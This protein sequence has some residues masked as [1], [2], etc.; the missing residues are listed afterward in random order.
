MQTTGVAKYLQALSGV[1]PGSA[2]R[3][4]PRTEDEALRRL[5]EEF[6]TVFIGEL[7]KEMRNT[8]LESGLL[9]NS[10][11]GRIYREMFD[12][13]LAGEMAGSG[14]LG[15]GKMVYDELKSQAGRK[16]I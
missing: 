14:G 16:T 13:T 1:S 12:D 9:G 10:R 6:E 15:I 2:R 7:L 3:E 8:S 4:A 11:A 5:S